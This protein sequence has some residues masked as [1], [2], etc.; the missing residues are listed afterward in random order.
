MPY[1]PDDPKAN[2]ENAYS[3]SAHMN[4][5]E[6]L[7]YKIAAL[8]ASVQQGFRRLD[9]RM[10]RFQ[11]DLHESSLA[12]NNR[13]TELDKEVSET[14]LRKRHRMDK[15]EEAIRHNKELSDKRFQERCEAT[16]HRLNDIE[17]WQKVI[18]GKASII[19]TTGFAFWTIF[20]PTIRNLFGIPN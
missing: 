3:P 2:K 4:I 12:I 6:Q 16:D 18:I 10:D 7:L 17:T 11:T 20:A 13:I 1:T 5:T 8:D 19:L 9:E 14:F 15:I